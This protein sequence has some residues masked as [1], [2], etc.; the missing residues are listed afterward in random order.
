MGDNIDHVHVHLAP[1]EVLT[2][3]LEQEV[4]SADAQVATAASSS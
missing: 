2:L 1:F 3:F 4:K